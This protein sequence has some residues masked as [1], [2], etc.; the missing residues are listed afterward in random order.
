MAA[1]F[2][3]CF[4][5]FEVDEPWFPY[6]KNKHWYFNSRDKR[7]WEEARVSCMLYTVMYI[8]SLSRMYE[9][10]SILYLFS[11]HV[12]FEIFILNVRRVRNKSYKNTLIKVDL[13]NTLFL[14]L[15]T[16]KCLHYTHHVISELQ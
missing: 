6:T 15:E 11:V 14:K 10:T 1:F 2:F 5:V 8:S 3:I 9:S 12:Y 16:C 13:C 7:T 4:C